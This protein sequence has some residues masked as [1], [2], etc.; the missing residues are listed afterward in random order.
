MKETIGRK[1]AHI[2]FEKIKEEY[3]K[4]VEIIKY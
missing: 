4:N 1:E 3:Y 2:S